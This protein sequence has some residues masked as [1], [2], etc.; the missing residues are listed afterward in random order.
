MTFY[1][2]DGSVRRILDRFLAHLER[3][4]LSID[5]FK[6]VRFIVAFE[7]LGIGSAEDQI[8]AA[9]G[10][11]FVAVGAPGNGAGFPLP[12]FPPD[13]FGVDLFD[14]GM[15]LHTSGGNIAGGY[16]GT[17]VGVGKNEMISVTVIAGGGDDQS[18]L[19]Q[20]RSVDAL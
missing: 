12:K 9:D 13:D 7:T 10:M 4:P 3:N 1:T 17:C 8:F 2:R 11:G 5:G 15:T 20:S 16:G 19:K 6:N 18:L 14:A